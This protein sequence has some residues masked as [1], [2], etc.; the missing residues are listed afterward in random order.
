MSSKDLKKEES[1]KLF[2]P[3]EFNKSPYVDWRLT[4]M[5]LLALLISFFTMIFS[6]SDFNI[7]SFSETSSSSKENNPIVEKRTFSSGESLTYLLS[8]ISSRISEDEE[9]S[10]LK[11][12]IINNRLI[13]SLKEN[14][15]RALSKISNLFSNFSNRIEINSYLSKEK[16]SYYDSLKRAIQIEEIFTSQGYDKPI[17][18][19]ASNLD[20]KNIEDLNRIDVIVLPLNE[21]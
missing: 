21:D 14:D 4:L 20:S 6:M 11:P 7:S 13:I 12:T 9:L 3:I 2:E 8:I 17:N 19:K 10:G 16:P 15:L 1:L 5:D 18:I